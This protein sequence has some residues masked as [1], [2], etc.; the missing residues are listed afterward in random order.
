VNSGL[1]ELEVAELDRERAGV[2]LDRRDVRNRLAQAL[3]LEPLERGLLDVDQV[4]EV[5][6]VL[7]T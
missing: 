7:Q 6:D 1:P 4:G 3:V 2:V 5:E